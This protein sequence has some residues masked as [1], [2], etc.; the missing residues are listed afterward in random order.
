MPRR[1]GINGGTNRAPLS[2][3]VTIS[4][5]ISY[6]LRHGAE[7]E[8]LKLDQNGYAN[9]ADLVRTC[10]PCSLL[11]PAPETKLDD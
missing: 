7:R 4:K 3:E 1:G 2:R 9:C 5:K 11:L 8:G 6:I 10:F